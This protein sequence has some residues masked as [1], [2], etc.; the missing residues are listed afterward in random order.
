LSKRGVP[1]LRKEREGNIVLKEHYGKQNTALLRCKTCKKTFSE[2]RGTTFFGLHTPKETVL[3]SMAML[4]EKGSI[5]GTARAMGANKD[6]VALWLKRAGEHCEEV[7]EYLLRDLNLSQVQIDEIWTFIKK[8]R[9]IGS[10]MILT[11]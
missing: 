5:R 10:P 7:T 11:K 9:K 4:V 6:S 2:N 1:G 3:R 8:K